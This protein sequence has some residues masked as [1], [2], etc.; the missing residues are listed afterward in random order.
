MDVNLG[1]FFYDIFHWLGEFGQ[2]FIDFFI[3][4][5][6][7]AIGGYVYWDVSLLDILVDLGGGLIIGLL[8]WQALRKLII[9]I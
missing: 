2:G 7:I 8:I 5:H 3:T 6:D 4:E 1:N 9:G